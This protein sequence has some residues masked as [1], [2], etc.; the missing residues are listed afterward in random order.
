MP[1][2]EGFD[3]ELTGCPS[4]DAVRKVSLAPMLMSSTVAFTSKQ[5]VDE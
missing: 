3:S 1:L 2:H 4:H 5:P